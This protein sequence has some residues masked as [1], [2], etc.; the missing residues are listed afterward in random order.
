MHPQTIF[1][2]LFFLTILFPSC[3]SKSGKGAG[4]DSDGFVV[5]KVIRI[6]DG[7]TYHLLVDSNRTLKVRMEGIDAPERGMPFYRV[8]KDY[9]G[10]L[11]FNKPVKLKITGEDRNGRTLGFTY[12]DDG[13]ELGHEMIKAG[14]AW[15]FR[16]Y[17]DDDELADLETEARKAKRGLWAENNPT[18][19]WEYRKFKRKGV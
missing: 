10:Q 14:M 16:R 18:P 11:C 13:R 4:D 6:V 17:N 9:L 1:L 8:S 12:L 15:H 5:G 7:D 3:H 19:P 2:L